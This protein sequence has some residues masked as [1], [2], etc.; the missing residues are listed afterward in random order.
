MK[1]FPTI[2]EAFEEPAE[3]FKTLFFPLLSIDLSKMGKGKGRVH[4]ISVW[5]NGG[6]NDYMIEDDISFG[7]DFIKFGWTGDKYTFDEK[8]FRPKYHKTLLK[9]YYAIEK[10]YAAN[11]ADYLTPVSSA[12]SEKGRMSKQRKLW[13]KVSSDY[14]LY[15]ESLINYWVTRDKYLETGKLIQGSAYTDG[16]NDEIRKP[17]ISLSKTKE[18]KLAKELVGK[19]CGYNYKQ[20]DV[21]EIALYIDR[22]QHKV[23]QKFNWD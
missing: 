2:E 8:L 21:D 5:G 3:I 6:A 16:C 10:E 7:F 17:F 13:D 19:V 11:K 20:N 18:T 15:A 12:E 9:W 1:L 14:S 4:F 22:K 23:F